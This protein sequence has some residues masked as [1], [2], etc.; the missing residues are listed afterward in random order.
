VKV[1]C[2]S[3]CESRHVDPLG[4]PYSPP[5]IHS[6]F[7]ADVGGVGVVI[8]AIDGEAAEVAVHGEADLSPAAA[9]HLA[10]VILAAADRLELI[11]GEQGQ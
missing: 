1:T 8:E 10:A 11:L 7:V 3:W 5:W 4:V 9:R 6:T 2:P